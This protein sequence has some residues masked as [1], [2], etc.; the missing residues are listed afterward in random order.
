MANL[1]MMPFFCR[2]MSLKK[3]ALP[4]LWLCGF[5]EIYLV[6]VRMYLCVCVCMC[7][8]HIH[9]HL[10]IIQSLSSWKAGCSCASIY[11]ILPLIV[12]GFRT[13]LFL[14]SLIASRITVARYALE[15]LEERNPAKNLHEN[16]LHVIYSVRA[17]ILP[18]VAKV[19][20]S[21]GTAIPRPSAAFSK[22][23]N[24]C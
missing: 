3:V 10:Y 1:W 24:R 17:D 23:E 5:A 13:Q 9:V 2:S 15:S 18:S 16:E 19:A 6:Y 4:Q 11:P 20:N 22:Y 21:L 8:H 12:T 14:D 7:I